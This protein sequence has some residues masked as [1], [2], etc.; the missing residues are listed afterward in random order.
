MIVVPPRRRHNWW[1]LLSEP[2]H[3]CFGHLCFGDSR[4]R[5]SLLD[6]PPAQPFHSAVRSSLSLSSLPLPTSSAPGHIPPGPHS[7]SPGPDSLRPQ[8]LARPRLSSA[9]AALARPRLFSASTHSSTRPGHVSLRSQQHSLDHVFDLSHSS[10]FAVS[11]RWC[12]ACNARPSRDAAR[13]LS[14]YCTLF[15]CLSPSTFVFFFLLLF[16][17]LFSYREFFFAHNSL[18]GEYCSVPP[19]HTTHK[20]YLQLW[21]FCT[22]LFYLYLTHTTFIQRILIHARTFFHFRLA[23]APEQSTWLFLS[24]HCLPAF[25]LVATSLSYLIFFLS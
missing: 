4:H 12:P 15:F 16:V 21:Y 14:R 10:R 9:P 23:Q 2:P 20:Q 7:N 3:R 13:R 8:Q 24:L 5:L 11:P 18:E 1:P 17:A 25:L 6:L 22:F 19:S